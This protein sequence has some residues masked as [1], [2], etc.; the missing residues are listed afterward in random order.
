MPSAPPP[1]TRRTATGALAVGMLAVAGCDLDDLDPRSDPGPAAAPSASAPPEDADA[2]LVDGVLADLATMLG[3]VSGAARD[4][5]RSFRGLAR[6]HRR[7]LA[8]L[9]AGTEPSPG[10][11]VLTS[12]TL[13]RHEER[14]QRRLATAA[15]AAGSGELARV[16]AAMSAAVGQQL[17][18]LAATG[19]AS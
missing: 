3:E 5:R 14:L 4:D 12:V 15:V 2:T 9:G 7:H 16:L 13:T 8:L 6:L 19:E 11:A 18:L 17:A 1:V 10:A